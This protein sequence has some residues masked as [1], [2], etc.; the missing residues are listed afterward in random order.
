MARAQ[1]VLSWCIPMVL[2]TVVLMVPTIAGAAGV[3][4]IW[5]DQLRVSE[6]NSDYGQDV[7]VA[8]NGHFYAPLNLPVGA[9]ITKITYYHWGGDP[10]VG[11][12]PAQTGLEISRMKMGNVD[13]GLGMGVSTDSTGM[14]IPVNVTLLGDQIIKAG[15]RYYIEIWSEN[16]DS[17]LL[18]VKINY[19]E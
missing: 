19:Q 8:R 18:G 1:M 16:M 15:Y 17:Y 2:I 3:I 4:K 5:P 9:R 14:V 6:P 7:N 12:L 10:D 13:E 11:Y